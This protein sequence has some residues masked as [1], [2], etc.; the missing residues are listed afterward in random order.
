MKLI[1]RSLIPALIAW[2][3]VLWGCT[4]MKVVSV[5]SHQGPDYRYGTPLALDVGKIQYFVNME[6]EP[7]QGRIRL[8]FLNNDKD[9]VKLLRED[10][11]QAKLTGPEGMVQD[12]SFRYPPSPI[13]DVASYRVVGYQRPPI[14]EYR[15]QRDWLKDLSSFR[16]LVQIPLGDTLYNVTFVY[17]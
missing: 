13:W 7:S 12:F 2:A 14:A 4:P 3:L 9:P 8:V 1:R 5:P 10:S 17:P 16:L 6:Y 15:R 11:L